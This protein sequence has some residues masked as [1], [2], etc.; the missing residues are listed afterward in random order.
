VPRQEPSTVL[1]DG[2]CRVKMAL[3][4]AVVAM[5]ASSNPPAR[6]GAVPG[7]ATDAPPRPGVALVLL[8]VLLVPTAITLYFAI[9]LSGSASWPTAQARVV[10]SEIESRSNGGPGWELRVALSFE[11]EGRAHVVK[12]DVFWDED[13]DRAAAAQ[14]EW[15]DGRT[16]PLRYPPDDPGWA[17]LNPAGEAQGLW[18]VTVLMGGACALLGWIYWLGRARLAAYRLRQAAAPAPDV[19]PDVGPAG[20]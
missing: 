18:V 5:A 9:H 13:Y 7:A 15:S 4:I 19:G 10:G 3:R 6:A 8:L 12:R 16:V 2:F 11:V 14:A 20:K 17:S 1:H